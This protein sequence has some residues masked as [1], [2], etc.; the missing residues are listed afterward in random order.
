MGR[1]RRR[2][3]VGVALVAAV[4][5]VLAACTSDDGGE[6]GGSSVPPG[7]AV[8]A[9]DVLVVPGT[10][11]ITLVGADPETPVTL[12]DAD[13]EDVLTLITDDAG[14]AHTAYVPD[15][16][17]TVETGGANIIP[18]DQGQSL[19]PGTYAFRVGEGDDAMV[20]PAVQVTAIDDH[21][22]ESLYEGQE[23]GG[24]TVGVLGDVAEGQSLEDGFNY[25]EMRDG[26]LLSAMVRFPDPL[27]YGEGP[28]P[29]VVEYSGYDPISN[30]DSVQPGSRIAQALGYATVGVSLR[31][32]GCSGGTFDVFSPA[33][34]ADGYDVIEIVGRQPWVKGN[35]VGM[36]GLS[37]SGILQLYTAATNPPHLAAITPQSVIADPLVQQWP[38]G[39]YNAGFT[40]QWLAERDREA[41]AGGVS[42]VVERA[43]GG[44]ATCAENL[45]LRSQNIDF[46]S[47][48][49][50]LEFR[51]PDV[52]ERDLRLLVQQIDV[53]VLITGAF[54]DEQT[55]PLFT[56]MLQDFTSAPV[57]RARLWNGR[58][59]DGYS[60][61]NTAAW[62]E[63]L[64]LYVN[65]EVP[66]MDELLL[67]GLPPELAKEFKVES[68]DIGDPNRLLA[69][70]GDDLDAARAAYEAEP[71]VTVIF[72]NGAG[73]DE[74]GEPGGTFSLTFDEWPPSD[75][76]AR[77]WFLGPD[78]ALTD[79]EPSD[80]G[81]D[82][83]RHDPEAGAEDFFGEAG[84]Q[85]LEPL[86][87]IDWTRYEAG[88]ELVYQTAPLAEDLLLAGPGEVT[89]WVGSE[90]DEAD[91][92]VTLTEVTPDGDEVLLQQGYLRIGHRAVD[93]ERSR[94]LW[95]EH[96][97]REEDYE[98]IP[99][100]ERVEARILLPSV[101]AP[102]RSGSRLRLQIASPGRNH[103]TWL[104]EGPYDGSEA[105]RHTIG[106]SPDEPSSITLSTLPGAEI[107]PERPP[108]GWLR[109]QPC[110][111]AEPVVNEAA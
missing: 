97:Y 15:E 105:P 79:G 75:A 98:P 7:S 69:E 65:D 61:M 57:F 104:F 62:F 48:G 10:Q 83:F 8:T 64:E 35:Q 6:A 76:E 11:E 81:A 110:R 108:C 50:S 92:Q 53:P 95:V 93:E 89:L 37:Y 111:P 21:P 2:G 25:L 30:P 16:P 68:V 80:D 26:T 12:L 43:E 102:V 85:L 31:G 63:F 72:E 91:V 78:G 23:L 45:Q 39:I 109:G 94:P 33:Q 51:P 73:G 46:E 27:I 86:W 29:T 58:H 5:L 22:D 87:D 44:D 100:G 38:G 4:A 60:P 18:T 42:W 99:E 47:F 52:D 82:A 40:K 101:A 107:P 56:G 67:V 20:T 3:R 77:T 13:G 66:E 59:P 88:H 90:A 24:V 19:K 41:E 9:G 96:S 70:H 34:Q 103:G 71:P 74:P 36:V 1:G 28:W 49:R 32:T 55:G 14:Q 17:L 84:Y 54:Q 106:R